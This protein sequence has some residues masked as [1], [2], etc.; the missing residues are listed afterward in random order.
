MFKDKA[1]EVENF[2]EYYILTGNL[3]VLQISVGIP[4]HLKKMCQNITRTA[5]ISHDVEHKLT[6][7]NLRLSAKK[8]CYKSI[9]KL[10]DNN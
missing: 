9:L 7:R 10:D 4:Y 5:S 8:K 1:I 3:K 6:H 2:F